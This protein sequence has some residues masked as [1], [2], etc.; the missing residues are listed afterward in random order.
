MTFLYFLRPEMALKSFQCR[1]SPS[2]GKTYEFIF[3][4]G[5][6]LN[7]YTSQRCLF[8]STVKTIYNIFLQY[9]TGQIHGYM[10]LR[11]N[12]RCYNK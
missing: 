1:P 11:F 5:I 12:D 6:D 8:I 10:V 2:S 4:Y 9:V 3:Y 7:I